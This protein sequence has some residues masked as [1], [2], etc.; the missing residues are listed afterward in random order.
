[1]LFYLFGLS[2]FTI[3]TELRASFELACA[4][5]EIAICGV[6]LV[7]LGTYIALDHSVH[8]GIKIA[9]PRKLELLV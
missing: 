5:E 2:I 8:H 7:L 1:M 4:V 3:Q 6:H 9:N